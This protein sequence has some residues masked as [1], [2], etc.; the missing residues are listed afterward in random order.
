MTKAGLHLKNF[1][2]L[3]SAEKLRTANLEDIFIA[4]TMHRP[5]IE[6]PLGLR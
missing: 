1:D 5:G 6:P 4:C 2:E 3:E